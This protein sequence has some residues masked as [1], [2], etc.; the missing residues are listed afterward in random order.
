M[1]VWSMLGAALSLN[2]VE[3]RL[4]GTLL[5]GT[6]GFSFLA[7]APM[8][9]KA[10]PFRR[11]LKFASPTGGCGLYWV[12]QKPAKF[13]RHIPN[14]STKF[15]RKENKEHRSH[16]A[17]CSLSETPQRCASAAFRAVKTARVRNFF[18][19]ARRFGSRIWVRLIF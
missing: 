19:P 18:G 12:G 7:R 5:S 6:S 2:L 16:H 9:A 17:L 10:E 3:L 8:V 1:V 14:A 15:W 13:L 4:E 11:K